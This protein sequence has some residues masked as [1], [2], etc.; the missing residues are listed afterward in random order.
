[1]FSNLQRIL[2]RFSDRQ[3]PQ[4]RQD[5]PKK[6]CI[7]KERTLVVYGQSGKPG[8]NDLQDALERYKLSKRRVSFRE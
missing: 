3:S 1:M 5:L 7:R 4:N 2:N 8:T 6:G